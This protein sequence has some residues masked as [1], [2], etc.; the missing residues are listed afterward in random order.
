MTGHSSKDWHWR[1]KGRAGAPPRQVRAPSAG[2]PLTHTA[3]T[4]QPHELIV[5]LFTQLQ[6]PA[7]LAQQF[8]VVAIDLLDGLANLVGEGQCHQ[9][10]SS[11][12]LTCPAAAPPLTA[13]S[14]LPA[15]DW[16]PKLSCHTSDFP[17]NPSG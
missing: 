2:H 8:L 5:A 11:T 15:L 4:F 12:H 3:V 17:N 10:A 16:A 1:P 7:V 13:C 14:S 9:G 6:L